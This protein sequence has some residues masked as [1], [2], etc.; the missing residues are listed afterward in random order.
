MTYFKNSKYK[1]LVTIDDDGRWPVFN[2]GIRFTAPDWYRPAYAPSKKSPKTST[3]TSPRQATGHSLS[4]PHAT[5]P[6]CTT[7]GINNIN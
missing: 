3:A 5:I 1:I 6:P 7:T 2:N 4:R